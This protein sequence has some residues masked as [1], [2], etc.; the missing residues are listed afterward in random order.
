MTPLLFV[1]YRDA[2][3]GPTPTGIG[4]TLLLALVA[5]LGALVV[6]TY[7]PE[8]SRTSVSSPC[9][10]L[11]VVYVL[12]AGMVLDA[13]ADPLSGGLALAMVAFGLRQRLRGAAACGPTRR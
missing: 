11:A 7:V 1:S 2:I 6:A 10:S 4:W 8:R 9:A 12:F 5:V 13:P 3:D